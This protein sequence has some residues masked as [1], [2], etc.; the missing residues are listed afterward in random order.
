MPKDL[1]DVALRS[2]RTTAEQVTKKLALL[3]SVVTI[4]NLGIVGYLRQ[5]FSDLQLATLWTSVAVMTPLTLSAAAVSYLRL[6]SDRIRW[7]PS[8]FCLT[9]CLLFT[10]IIGVGSG[11]EIATRAFCSGRY[12]HLHV[13]FDAPSRLRSLDGRGLCL[14]SVDYLS[15]ATPT[16]FVPSL[17]RAYWDVYGAS[18]FLVSVASGVFLGWFW[19]LLSRHAR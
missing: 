7:I 5:E 8:Y 16:K 2:V 19:H 10:W 11:D 1:D 13:G 4:I 14:G 6:A 12:L 15:M 17:F 9:G 18:G 3:G